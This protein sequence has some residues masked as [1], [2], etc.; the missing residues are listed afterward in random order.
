MSRAPEREAD[1][2]AATDPLRLCVFTTVALLAW[3]VGP[4]VVVAFATL[5]FVGYLRARRDGATTSRCVLRDIR[6]VLGYLAAVGLVAG[7]GV[8]RQVA[9]LVG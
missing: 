8:V 1:R 3:L 7:A 6:L 5:G 2:R 9:A 4:V